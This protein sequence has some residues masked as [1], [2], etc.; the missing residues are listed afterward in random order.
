MKAVR[1]TDT[2]DG[3]RTDLVDMDFDALR[4]GDVVIRARYSSLNY[5][6]ALAITGQGQ[7]AR[8][9]PLNAGIDVAGTVES[10]EDARFVPGDEVLITGWFM[11]E[12][13]DGGLADYVRI[14]GTMS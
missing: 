11:S 3:T 13:R 7:I 2:Q 12:T 4:A 8:T 1:I 5:K 9:R 6:D 10:S 14:P